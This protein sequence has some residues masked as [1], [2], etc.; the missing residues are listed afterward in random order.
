MFSSGNVTERKR[1]GSLACSGEI[2]VDLFAG[3]G[4][5]TVP[6]LAQSGASF[7]YACE[8]NPN[9]IECLKKNLDANGVAEK[10]EVP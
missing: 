2:V 8:W 10:C 1:M 4:Y 7:L 3:I 5:F 6:I 9:S